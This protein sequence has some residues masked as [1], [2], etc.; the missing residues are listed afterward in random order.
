MGGVPSS[1]QALA[2]LVTWVRSP[3]RAWQ[4]AFLKYSGLSPWAHPNMQKPVCCPVALGAFHKSAP[5]STAMEKTLN[6][7][8]LIMT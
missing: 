1:A 2:C 4:G 7:R 8:S 3:R 5:T 6:F